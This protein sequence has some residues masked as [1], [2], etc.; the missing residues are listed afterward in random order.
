MPRASKTAEAKQP[1]A[2]PLRMTLSKA[3]LTKKINK[4]PHR[5]EVIWDTEEKGLSVLVS[6]GPKHARRGT[7]T[8]RVCFYLQGRPGKP[9]YVKLGRYPD[10]KYVY[11]Y[12]DKDGK[13]I[14]KPCSDID[15]MRR[16][17]SDIRNRAKDQGIDPRR[18]V[19]SDVFADVVKDFIEL[20]AKPNTRSWKE[21]ERIFNTYVLPE[22]GNEKI[23]NIKRGKHVTT[24][25]DKIAAKQLTG[26]GNNKGQKLGGRVTADAVLAQLSV[27]FNWHAKRDENFSSPLVKKMRR[28]PPPQERARDRVL[29]DAELRV[30]WPILGDLGVYGA[31]VK[32]MLLTAQRVHKVSKMRRADLKDNVVIQS[33][34]QGNEFIPEQRVPNVWDPS[35]ANDPENKKVS[36]V[37]LARMTR[38]IIDAVPIIDTD[39]RQDFVFSVDGH[40]PINGW[41]KDKKKLDSLMRAELQR[42][43]IE[44]NA[45]QLRDLRRTARTLMSRAGIGGEVAE[46]CVGHVMTAIRKTYDRYKYLPEKREAFDTL[47]AWVERLVNPPENNVTDLD[48]RRR[49][50]RRRADTESPRPSA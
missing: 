32:C 33:H 43:G 25:L 40:K 26:K 16:A 49:R 19:A 36:V 1:R 34:Q 28:A 14:V 38:A 21:T 31:V 50:G 44:W 12:K 20:H 37:P 48:A 39:Q 8:F 7:V 18:P 27:L 42:R 5:Q 3:E 13:D 30:M 17:A 10:G 11:P 41:S 4:R 9:M 15:A 35:R 29:S 24:L 45:W 22:W 6:R 23:G 47:A 2:A 46:H